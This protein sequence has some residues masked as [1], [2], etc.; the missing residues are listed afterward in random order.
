MTT[1]IKCTSCKEEYPKDKKHF[2]NKKNLQK[3]DSFQTCP[4]CGEKNFMKVL[5]RF[6]RRPEHY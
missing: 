3:S 5:D 4:F 2:F 6:E 1:I